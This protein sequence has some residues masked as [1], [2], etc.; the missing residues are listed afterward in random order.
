MLLG[1]QK[2][3]SS[4]GLWNS[5]TMLNDQLTDHLGYRLPIEIGVANLTVG[6]SG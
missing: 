5:A 4:A 2:G 3:A 1:P 6:L